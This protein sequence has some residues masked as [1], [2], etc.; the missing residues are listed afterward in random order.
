[1][2]RKLMFPGLALV[3]VFVLVAMTSSAASE[4]T[5]GMLKT[6]DGT[7]KTLL[8]TVDE[9]FLTG[10]SFTAFSQRVECERTEYT[11]H[12]WNATPH[13]AVPDKATTATVTAHYAECQHFP[14]ALPA[15]VF[16]NECDFVVHVGETTGMANHYKATLDII[17]P[18]DKTIQMGVYAD[19]GHTNRICTLDVISATGV[20]GA[21]W[22][23]NPA[24]EG[25]DIDLAG[26]FAPFTIKK[27]GSVCGAGTDNAG[28]LDINTTIE[29]S[30]GTAVTI[31]H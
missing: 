22:I 8:G 21:D 24:G 29:A 16:T 2:L 27:S 9:E 19:A 1:M 31:V 18:Q 15:T 20:G 30:D 26:T 4:G 7:A 28:K 10:N 17:C 23:H 3:A 11:G 13:Q 5:E 25:D 6:S 12:K 14:S